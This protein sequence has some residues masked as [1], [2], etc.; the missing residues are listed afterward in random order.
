MTVWRS[1][2]I[3]VLVIG[4]QSGRKTG[5]C[6]YCVLGFLA[7]S[8]IALS[9]R[10]LSTHGALAAS[11]LAGSWP[12]ASAHGELPVVLMNLAKAHAAALCLLAWKIPSPDMAGRVAVITPVE[13]G[14]GWT[15]PTL[16][17]P[18]AFMW[19]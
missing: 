17:A 1:G 11:R 2:S 5:S 9:G 13:L 10:E 4:P 7:A 16:S 8:T 3:C 12:T 19:S 14:N 15:P 18:S 6:T